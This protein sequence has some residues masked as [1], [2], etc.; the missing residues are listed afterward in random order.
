MALL[1]SA[2]LAV[3]AFVPVA[4]A[5]EIPPEAFVTKY[6]FDDGNANDESGE[7][8]DGTIEGVVAG[9]GKV[10]GALEF[11]GSDGSYVEVPDLGEHDEVTVAAWFK[12]TGKVGSW[13]AIYNVD[14]RSSGWLHHQLYPDNRMGFS[15]NANP[16]GGNQF[17]AST[18]DDVILDEWHH[19]AVV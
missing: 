7:G 16:G 2:I 18:Y 6:S 13:R 5:Q 4:V 17:G 10:G 11:D 12:V 9:E 14:G 1:F 15:I 8:N 3:E 19:S